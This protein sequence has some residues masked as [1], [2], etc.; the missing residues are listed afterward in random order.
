MKIKWNRPKKITSVLEKGDLLACGSESEFVYLVIAESGEY[1]LVLLSECRL[2]FLNKQDA[3]A[4]IKWVRAQHEIYR[5]IK[6]ND[7][8]LTIHSDDDGGIY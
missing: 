5:L 4:I 2:M 6:S 1:N 3:I 8:S 7:L